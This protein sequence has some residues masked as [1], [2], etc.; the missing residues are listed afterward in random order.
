MQKVILNQEKLIKLAKKYKK[1]FEN[2]YINRFAYIVNGNPFYFSNFKRGDKTTGYAILSPD[3][4]NKEDH[5]IA[6]KP[7]LHYSVTIRNITTDVKYRANVDFRVL[8]EVRDYLKRV[9]EG[10]VLGNKNEIVYKRSLKVIQTMLDNQEELKKAYERAIDQYRRDKDKGFITDD[11]IKEMK[12]YLPIFMRLQYK[13]FRDRYDNREDFDVIYENRN[14]KEIKQF[15]QFSDPNTLREMTSKR[16]VKDLEN[17]LSEVSYGKNLRDR[18]DD[19]RDQLALEEFNKELEELLD[20]V[21]N[22]LRNP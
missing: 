19:E 10:N 9:V 17:A 2:Y 12:N 22:N 7:L 5:L 15:D 4:N 20:W 8:Y 18:T 11:D 3:S 6:I 14:L 16:A 21:R 1:L 13:Q